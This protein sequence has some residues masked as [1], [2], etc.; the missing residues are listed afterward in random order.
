MGDFLDWLNGDGK[1]EFIDHVGS[2]VTIATGV[3][4]IISWLLV[5]TTRKRRKKK[6]ATAVAFLPYKEDNKPPT[7]TKI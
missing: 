4:G 1:F 3:S 2:L 7:R 6:H 5:V